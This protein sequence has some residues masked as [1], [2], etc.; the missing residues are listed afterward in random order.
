M[1]S[2]TFD[3]GYESAY[4]NALPVLDRFGFKATWYIITG[5]L[6]LPSYMT[7]AELKRLES[8][9]QEIGGHTVSHLHLGG[10]SDSVAEE[11]IK[12]SRLRLEATGFTHVESFAY[13]FGD[14]NQATPNLVR[15]AG[16]ATARTILWGQN[17]TGDNPYLLKSWPIVSNTD[18]SRIKE[19]ID[20][21]VRNGTWLI[22]CF[23]RVDEDGNE[24]S[25]RHELLETV[26]EYLSSQRVRVVTVS[27][28]SRG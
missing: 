15:E 2:I 27:E 18:V 14:Y 17:T 6:G 19:E 12:G 9:G 25:V 5:K 24:I 13:P 8:D 20:K 1:I 28:G 7:T 22:L 21:A 26:F 4:K 3:D 23:H 16:F 10:L 11:E